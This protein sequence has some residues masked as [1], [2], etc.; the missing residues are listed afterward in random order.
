M[1]A[2]PIASDG[3]IY[4]ANGKGEIHA[5]DFG[6]KPLWTRAFSETLV[7]G[8]PPSEAAFEA[9][10]ALFES[11]LIACSSAGGVYALDPATGATRWEVRTRIP[12]LG[13]PALA[14]LDSAVPNPRRL[15]LIDQ[16]QGSLHA[17]DFD[18]GNEIWK[19]QSIARCDGS[20]TANADVAVFGSCNA[21]LHFFS[22]K[23]GSLVR[24]V[25]MGVDCEIAGGIAFAGNAA[26][27]GSRCGKVVQVNLDTGQIDWENTG[28]EGE[29]M[30]TPAV[31]DSL[32]A[33]TAN[34]GYVFAL[35]RA[36]GKLAWRTRL[37]DTPSSPVLS[38]NKLVVSAGG[39]L[40]VLALE[41][42]RLVWS[43][44]VSDDITS[45]ALVGDLIVVG[46]DDGSV[47]AFAPKGA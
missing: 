1:P 35:D 30:E 45:P 6:G 20:P 40:F 18:N 5:I 39:S 28:C 23:D 41:D 8:R 13:S 17:L 7:E 42:G 32:V 2:T 29:A 24:E 12:L 31:N 16:A 37:E 3:R 22:T 38:R 4:A 26:Y 11:T 25:E 43:Y 44:D 9:P 34:D 27:S 15:L 46:C 36:S 47:A 14:V 10:L 33:F 19:S 21:A